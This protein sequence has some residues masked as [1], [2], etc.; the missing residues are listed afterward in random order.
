MA[1]LAQREK[2]GKGQAIQSALYENNIFLVAQHM[3]QYAVTGQAPAPMPA[4]I[5]PWGIY[6]V[7]QVKDQAQIFLAVTGDSAWVTF[8]NA[9]G[10]HDLLQDPRLQHNND[11][12]RQRHWLIDRLRAQLQHYSAAE[13]SQI[14]ETHGLPY[15]PITKPEDLLN[16]PHLN[17]TG[18]LADITLPDGRPAKTVLLPITLDGQRL[19]LRMNAPALGEHNHAL[20]QE[21]G[22]DAA[23]IAQLSQGL[24]RG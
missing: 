11:R 20:L 23:A 6:D 1:A 17:A 8:C 2:T 13:L 14:C 9:L 15:A 18:T 22:Y 16:D 19:N 4:R 24:G 5:S 21:L 12:V 10:L 3:M 7:F